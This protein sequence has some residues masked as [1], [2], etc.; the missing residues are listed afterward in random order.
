[1]TRRSMQD[2][3]AELEKQENI[4]VACKKPMYGEISYD[5]AANEMFDVEP[6][7]DIDSESHK[8][9]KARALLYKYESDEASAAA[10]NDE[11]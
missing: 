7:V 4:M 8:K 2:L 11:L 10:E 3:L 9:R 5:R 6:G 1:M